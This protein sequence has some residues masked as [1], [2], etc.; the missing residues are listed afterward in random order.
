MKEK[1]AWVVAVDMGYGH[2]RAAYPLKDIA[3]QRIITANSDKIILPKEKKMWSKAQ[4]IYERMSRGSS[5]FIGRIFFNL[6]DRIQSI[7]PY[8]PY[9][10]LSKPNIIVNYIDSKIKK[11]LAKSTIDFVK[12]KKL[13]F[14]T[15]FFIP[16]IAASYAKLSDIYCVVTDS[17]INR[18]WVAR[19]SKKSKIN[20]LAPTQHTVRRLLSY[21][22]P[23]DRIFLT[24]FPLPK[25]NLG[26][27][28]LLI[29]K[30]DIGNRL[31]NLDPKKVFIKRYKEVISK[32]IGRSALG[33]KSDHP[34]T[35]TFVVGGAGAQKE[36]AV[37]LLR[38][39]KNK[40]LKGE[41]KFNLVAGIRIEVKTYFEEQLQ[42]LSLLKRLGKNISI[43]FALDKKTYFSIFNLCL[44]KT[45]ILW[46]K[47]SELTFY[48]G[49]G[50][51][52]ILTP[53]IGSQEIYNRKWLHNIGAG[54]LQEDVRYANEWLYDWLEQGILAEAAWKGFL[55]AP[56]LGVYNIEE[57]VFSKRGKKNVFFDL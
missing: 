31:L 42:R 56:K 5:G 30:K 23:K 37:S 34:L 43:I 11:G 57:L 27:R 38:S 16:A 46:T 25:E 1:K 55:E 6:F 54:H 50:I 20:Y 44:R 35:I 36:I 53:P 19:E 8:Y 33:K 7:S 10:D 32:N 45:D 52:L 40:I 49:L 4:G 51:P 12:T 15:T 3:Y 39:L 29:L 48:A 24:G 18:A 14:I 22:V 2:Q 26:G 9:R 41:I 28:E 13:P 47:P 17:D 21:G